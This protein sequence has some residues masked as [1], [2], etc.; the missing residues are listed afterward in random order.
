MR[1]KDRKERKYCTNVIIRVLKGETRG[2]R[3]KKHERR[4]EEREHPSYNK[5]NP[6]IPSWGTLHVCQLKS[7]KKDEGIKH[8][9]GRKRNKTI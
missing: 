1:G 2:C 3:V 9:H 5:R 6:T 4:T 8:E 7:G